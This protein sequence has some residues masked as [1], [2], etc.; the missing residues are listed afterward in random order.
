VQESDLEEIVDALAS[1]R[2]V[3]RLVLAPE[4]FVEPKELRA[5]AKGK[6]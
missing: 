5:L 2:R 6:Q 4:D 1:D 3:E